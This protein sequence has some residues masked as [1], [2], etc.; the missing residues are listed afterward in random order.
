MFKKIL[1]TLGTPL[2]MA[3]FFVTAITGIMMF[4]HLGDRLVKGIHEWLSIVFV[5]GAVLHV[6][7]NWKPFRGYLKTRGFWLAA[8]AT[9]LAGAALL[10]PALGRSESG[11]RR[12]SR[13][14]MALAKSA[15]SAALADLAPVLSTTSEALV[16]RLRDKGLSIP[17]GRPTVADVARA[18]GRTPSEVLD[19]A[20]AP[21]PRS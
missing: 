17:D 9:T 12:P 21:P 16:A 14:S 4:F 18:S 6:A 15:E 1:K 5:L 3:L 8:A 7:R 19:L 20:V 11:D 10:V 2:P 13:G